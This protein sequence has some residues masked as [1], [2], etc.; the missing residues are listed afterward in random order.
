[1]HPEQSRQPRASSATA[2]HDSLIQRC[3]SQPVLL[4]GAM[5]SML[6][7]RGL[8]PGAPPDLWNLE[9]PDAVREVHEAYL[10]AGSQVVYTNTFGSSRLRLAA[11]GLSRQTEEINRAGV[12]IAASCKRPETLIAGDIGPTGAFLPPIGTADVAQLQDVF[13]EQASYLEDKSVNVLVIETMTDL[14]EALAAVSGAISVSSLPVIACLTFRLTPRGY[15]TIMGDPPEV[16]FK[17]LADEGAAVVG[18][19]CTLASGEMVNLVTEIASELQVP[20]LAKPNA[21]QPQLTPD[22]VVYPEAPAEFAENVRR[23]VDAGAGLVG[24]CCGST[25]EHL[26]AISHLL[27]G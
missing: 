5:G 11:V 25:P 16:S 3:R 23:M 15:F 13:A 1:M 27:H 10:S 7:Q 19:N 21:G 14:R 8:P 18:A 22:G 20:F 4:D 6:I 12:R 9:N 2:V 24:G 26:R 17:R